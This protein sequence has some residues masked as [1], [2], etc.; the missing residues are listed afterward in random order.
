MFT[1]VAASLH[2]R[3]AKHA[4]LGVGS[5][6]NGRAAGLD[7]LRIQLV[8]WRRSGLR[9]RPARPWD[10]C[11]SRRAPR[12][13]TP[14]RSVMKS[15]ASIDRIAFAASKTWVVNTNWPTGGIGAFR[16]PNPL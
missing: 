4:P 1:V 14:P 12:A 3:Q 10:A 16:N 7:P 5:Q 2:R 15:Y 8:N 11:A 13:P 9:C 6:G